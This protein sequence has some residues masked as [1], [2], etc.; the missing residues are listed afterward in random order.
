[1]SEHPKLNH[2]EI[3][4]YSR[5]LL[6]QEVGMEGQQKLKSAKVLCV[7]S[8]GLG[9]PILMYLAAAG[10]GR[11]GIVD[12]DIVDESNLQRQ[13]LHGTST[14]GQPKVLSAQER[15]LD[16]NPHIQIDIFEK[17]LRSDNALEIIQNYDIVV[18][19]TDNF[20]TRYLI[21]DA[22]VLLDKPYVYGSI[23]KFEGQA[24]VFNYKGGWIRPENWAKLNSYEKKESRDQQKDWIYDL[25]EKG[26]HY[27]DLYPDPPPPGL[28]PTCAE[29]GVLG[30]LP[31]IIGC[32][33]ANEVI[34]MILGIGRTLSGR[35]LSY[36]ALHMTF[37]EFKL[38]RDPNTP[39]IIEL[40][41]YQQFCGFQRK[42]KETFTEEKFIHISAQQAKEKLDNGWKP[43]VIDVRQT[44]EADIVSLA[45]VHVIQPHEQILDIT[46]Q[47]PNDRDILIHCK[48]GGRSV[49]A[50]QKLACAGFTRLYNLDGGIINWAK[51]IDTTLPVY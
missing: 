42:R 21:N 12:F 49:K 44:H 51:E 19:G 27:R 38:C 40:I 28:V 39:Q 48:M 46:D 41:D 20:P 24:S 10:V 17:S 45:F 26:P 3:E 35:I 37:K 31:G 50:C 1:M 14:V 23:F 33:Q 36:D 22:C 30:V 13:I 16:I 11:I 5:H 34:K 7:G 6:L 47:L 8:G 4:R 43:F 18:D 2:T 9:S 15:L 32:I 25:N 29:G